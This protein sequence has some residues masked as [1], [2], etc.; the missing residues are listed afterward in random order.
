[1]GSLV[2]K[3]LINEL[4]YICGHVCIVGDYSTHLCRT[5][6]TVWLGLI[7]VGIS[8]LKGLKLTCTN[9]SG[10]VLLMP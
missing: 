6:I 8:V 2:V 4:N 5:G 10:L 9:E 7:F 1:M 3:G